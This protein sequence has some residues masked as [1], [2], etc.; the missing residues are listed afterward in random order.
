MHFKLQDV[1]LKLHLGVPD[2]ERKRKQIV[3]I[4]VFFDINTKKSELSDNIIDT[5]NYQIIYDMIQTFSAI[6][7]EKP[8]KLLEKLH[9]DILEKIKKNKDLKKIKNL[10][11][12]ITKFPFET[13]AITISN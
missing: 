12:S 4:S 13:G 5:V 8:Y 6:S 7:E 11:V 2:G 10:K 3:F 9:R 1:Q